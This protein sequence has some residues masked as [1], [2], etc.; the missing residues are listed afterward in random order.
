MDLL[1]RKLKGHFNPASIITLCLFGIVTL[2][3]FQSLGFSRSAQMDYLGS[4]EERNDRPELFASL[5][6]LAESTAFEPD[7]LPD[8]PPKAK[9]EWVTV[10]MRVT[11]YCPCGRCCGGFSDGV[12]ASGHNISWGDR[13]VAASKSIPFGT[14]MIIHGYNNGRAVK[15]LDRGR[16]IKGN[17]LDVFYNTHHTAGRWG[18]K[19][20]DV[21]V[22]YNR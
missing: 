8:S 10:R 4:I 2:L 16:V 5:S 22:K 13:F 19:Y 14:E 18:V 15:V 21:K 6:G 7:D 11:S 3:V 17:R 1:K 9:Q 12:T 20:L